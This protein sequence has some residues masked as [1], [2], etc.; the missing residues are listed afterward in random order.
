MLVGIA[1]TDTDAELQWMAR[2]CL[3]LR[4]FPSEDSDRF[5]CSVQDINGEL[6]I[7]SQMNYT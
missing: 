7:I 5:D 2:K 1:S 4:L 3:E 6:L